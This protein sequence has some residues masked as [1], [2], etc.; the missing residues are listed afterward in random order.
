ML[1]LQVFGKIKMLK[2]V[3][4]ANFLVDAVKNSHR[5]VEEDSEEKSIFFYV[6]TLQQLRVSFYNMFIRLPQ[7]V[8]IL[9]VKVV[10]LLV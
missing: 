8:F 6:V 7:E 3:F 2:K 5:V 4:Y 10:Q 1:L 9:R